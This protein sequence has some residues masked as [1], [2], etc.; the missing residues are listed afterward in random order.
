MEAEPTVIDLENVHVSFGSADALRGVSLTVPQGR[1]HALLGVNG[2]GKSTTLKALVGL[3]P[4]RAGTVSLFGLD[5]VRDE[6]RVKER[7][8]WVPDAP[9]FYPWMTVRDALD[10]AASFRPEWRPDVEEH[11]LSRFA[12]DVT[13]PTTALSKGQRTLLALVA[14]VASDA[15]LLILDEPTSGLDPL[16]R[17]QFLEAVISTFQ[18]R[19]PERRTLLLSTHLISELEGIVDSFTVLQA[20]R[21][22]LTAES[23]EARSRFHRVR[24][25]FDE[26]PPERL[27][28]RTLRPV[29]HDGRMVELLVDEGPDEARSWL[30]ALGASRIEA[31]GLSLED[32]FLTTSEP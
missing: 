18:D 24:A 28:I 9:G 15:E 11:L 19:T 27:P 14:A 29:R 17:R 7:L 12:L 21:V 23:D 1:C 22:V 10:Y 4:V 31:S 2:A 32:I 25:W 13:A 5:P 16:V 8:G 26:H 3:V 6:A 30:T 20:G